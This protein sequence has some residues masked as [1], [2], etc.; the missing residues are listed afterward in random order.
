MTYVFRSTPHNILLPDTGQVSPAIGESEQLLVWATVWRDFELNVGD[1]SAI[2]STFYDEFRLN[3]GGY[4][5]VA[6]R[7]RGVLFDIGHGGNAFDLT[8]ASAALKAGFP[9]DTI[10][11]DNHSQ[12]PLSEPPHDLPLVMSKLG[13]AG[14]PEEA[15]FRAVTATPAAVLGL[16][17]EIGTLR[18][19]SCAD[20]C[21]L[22]WRPDGISTHADAFGNTLPGVSTALPLSYTPS[23]PQPDSRGRL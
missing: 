20:L 8:V 5:P 1:I 21:A 23:L 13:A 15:V 10:S 11:S 3:C 22:E 9:P 18:A 19:G 12:V 4:Y 14:M 2:S 7:E 16:S 6:A 17:G